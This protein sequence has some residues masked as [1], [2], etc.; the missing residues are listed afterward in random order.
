MRQEWRKPIRKRRELQW[1]YKKGYMTN[2][3]LTDSDE[4]AIVD[5]VKDHKELYDKTSEHFKDKTRKEFLLEQFAKSG[6][7]SVKTW[8]DLQRTRYGKL[9]QSKSGQAPKEVTERQ[10]WIQGKLGFLRSHIRC[11]WVSKSLVFK[12]QARGASASAT[13]ARDMSRAS[14][15][16]HYGDKHVVN[17]HQCYSLSK[18]LTPLQFQGT[19][20]STSRSCDELRT[21]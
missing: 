17:K 8:F 9:T 3:Y 16:R 14:T 6:K 18:S 11:K 4:E 21:D 15:D 13:T 20:W 2:I 7:L 12:S 19:L 1:H 5:L 10:T